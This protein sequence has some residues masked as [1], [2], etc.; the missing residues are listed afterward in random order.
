MGRIV[1]APAFARSRGTPRGCP[2]DGEFCD[3][4]QKGQ[5]VAAATLP[6]HDLEID[7]LDCL[8]KNAVE[9]EKAPAPRMRDRGQIRVDS[10]NDDRF[11]YASSL[12]R[13]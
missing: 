10:I 7:L 8:E 4:R 6:L 12:R 9:I 3:T 5:A 2:L 1:G 11:S 13:K